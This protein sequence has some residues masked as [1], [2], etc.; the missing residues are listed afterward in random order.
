MKNT[1][2]NIN[3]SGTFP[4]YYDLI[5][6]GKDYDKEAEIIDSVIRKYSKKKS[7]KLADVGCGTGN[8][9]IA[10]S[11]MGYRAYGFDVSRHMISIARGKSTGLHFECKSFEDVD[12]P[13]DVIVSLFDVVNALGPYKNLAGFFR[14]VAKNMKND[15]IFIFDAWNGSAVFLHPP[16]IKTKAIEWKGLKI[17][18]KVIPKTDFL[19]QVCT[20]KYDIKAYKNG[21]L[22]E[23]VH[24][25]LVIN[26]FTY[27]EIVNALD[28]SGLKVV[29]AFPY[30]EPSKKIAENDW[31]INFV[32][33]L[34]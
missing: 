4:K 9:T 25:S 34:R 19:R 27:N 18:R 32:C 22:A 6:K 26:F 28:D 11:R 30:K 10:F 14:S 2:K 1:N 16:E 31:K 7:L 12:E 21:R 20:L 29:Q 17:E 15:S 23:H 8:H 24:P 5:N 13:F 33:K 3:Y